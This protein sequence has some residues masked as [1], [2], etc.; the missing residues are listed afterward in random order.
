MENKN[1]ENDMHAV[2]IFYWPLY[3]LTQ[4]D[5]NEMTFKCPLFF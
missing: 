2:L 3:F 4:E 1:S 5:E